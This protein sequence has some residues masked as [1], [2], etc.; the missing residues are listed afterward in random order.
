MS[1]QKLDDPRCDHGKMINRV[2]SL[3]DD[4]EWKPGMG[5]RS[6]W[7]CAKTA[8]VLDA[9]AWVLRG[10][11]GEPHVYGPYTGTEAVKR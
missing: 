11:C 3:P 4:K 10:E 5:I 1:K 2:T 9:M 6:V 7:V 8:C